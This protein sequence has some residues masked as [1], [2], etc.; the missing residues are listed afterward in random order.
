[1]KRIR[2]NY[3]ALQVIK[4]AGP[5]L[6]KV[7]LSNYNKEL[8]HSIFDCALNVLNGNLTLKPCAKR[9]LRKHKTVHRK[10]ADKR[11]P[12]AAKRKT[13]VQR[14]GFLLPLLSAALPLLANLLLR[15]SGWRYLWGESC[16]TARYLTPHSP[17]A[18]A[19]YRAR[20]HSPVRSS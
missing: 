6:R 17:P 18:A 3:H 14:G 19:R 10:I 9:K 15:S 11:L 12:L 7:I 1:M 20:S 16:T 8:L 5:K 2:S 4:S 13:I